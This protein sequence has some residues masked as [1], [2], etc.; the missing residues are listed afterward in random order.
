M[1]M[2]GQ[3]L[4]SNIDFTSSKPVLLRLRK[5]T[6]AA[7]QDRDAATEPMKQKVPKSVQK[8]AFAYACILRGTPDT[9]R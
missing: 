5:S 4:D 9:V 3:L 8:K 6:M 1:E 7:K 2:T